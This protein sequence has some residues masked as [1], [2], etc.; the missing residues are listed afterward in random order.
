VPL[1][2][3]TGL[4][5]PLGRYVLRRAC[6]Q[7]A[8]WT[9]DG[10]RPLSVQVNVSARELEDPELIGTVTDVLEATGLEPERLT[11]EVTESVMI[12]DARS[13]RATLDALRGLGVELALDDFG[14]GYS[15]LSYMRSLP[16]NTLKVAKEFIDGLGHSAED[17]AF[18]RLIIE[19]ARMRGLRVV[20]EG[21][22]DAEQLNILRGLGCDSAQGFYFARPLDAGDPELRAA[23]GLG[24]G[25]RRELPRLA[26]AGGVRP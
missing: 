16:L 12:R 24:V 6:Q 19:L 13:G 9:R 18:V 14:T 1:A 25:D 15:S 17:R 20:A 3:R 23:V 11:L 21:V 22:E 7:A 8:D 4:I 26:T 10:G 5:V 2:E